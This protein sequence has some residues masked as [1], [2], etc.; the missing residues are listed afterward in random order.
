MQ[1]GSFGSVR[2]IC[3]TKCTGTSKY[4]ILTHEAGN[5][6]FWKDPDRDHSAAVR[7]PPPPL[8]PNPPVAAVADGA[9]PAPAGDR[10]AKDAVK[11][12]AD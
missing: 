11:A 9:G 8:S 4:V 1:A 3:L 12:V 5:T 10:G 7:W 2:K 6:Q